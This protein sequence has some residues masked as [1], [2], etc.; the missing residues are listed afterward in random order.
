MFNEQ[1]EII[2]K[3][4]CEY[5]EIDYYMVNFSNSTHLGLYYT[6]K[7]NEKKFIEWFTNHLYSL[8]ISELRNITEY[9]YIMY[10]RKKVCRKFAH[11]TACWNGFLSHPEDNL[12]II[13]VTK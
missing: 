2:I 6:K 8:K 7:G 3:K 9:P 5:A 1:M 4:M 13:S 12:S 11:D 10:R